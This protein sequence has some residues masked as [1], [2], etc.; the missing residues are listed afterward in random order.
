MF[1]DMAAVSLAEQAEIEKTQSGSFDEFV[2]AYNTS[3][4][5]CE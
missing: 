3:T 2:G 5:C 1:E 4:L